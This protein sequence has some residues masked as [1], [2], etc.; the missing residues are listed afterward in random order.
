MT[1]FLSTLWLLVSL[2]FPASTL[3][4][5]VEFLYFHGRTDRCT[6]LLPGQCC[7]GLEPGEY[8]DASEFSRYY[9]NPEIR[10]SYPLAVKI[11]RLL[12]YDIAAVWGAVD[13]RAPP[14]DM[15]AHCHGVPKETMIG[16][17]DFQVVAWDNPYAQ[18]DEAP[19]HVFSGVSY[20]RLPTNVPSDEKT[21]L[22][23]SAEGIL[24]L[25]WGREKWLSQEAKDMNLPLGNMKRGRESSLRGTAY[26]RPP[27]I[28]KYP[29]V[30]TMNRT[31]YVSTNTSRLYYKT[32]GGQTLNLAS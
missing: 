6:D 28:W 12:D 8:P 2:L 1:P 32:A 15:R 29:D 10:R 5:D 24:G 17:G 21:S 22:W 25:V 26:A 14:L 13:V 4:V 18:L 19:D 31:E 23:L 20:I 7:V 16:P 30:I 11:E 27:L 3:Q 9:G